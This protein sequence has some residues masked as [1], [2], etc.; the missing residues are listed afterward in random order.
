LTPGLIGEG[1]GE[2]QAAWSVLGYVV[3][4][5]PLDRAKYA[6]GCFAEL[7]SER[8][9]ACGAPAEQRP[10]QPAHGY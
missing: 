9:D 8:C 10:G 7:G 3:V 6:V 1:V 5:P 4:W 2:L